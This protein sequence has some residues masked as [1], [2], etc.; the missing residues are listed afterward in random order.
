MTTA[1]MRFGMM[2]WVLPDWMPDILR[3]LVR[4][5]AITPDC[6]EMLSARC[7]RRSRF[8]LQLGNCRER[9]SL[10]N[11]GQCFE[12]GQPTRFGLAAATNGVTGSVP[13][14]LRHRRDGRS[15]TPPGRRVTTRIESHETVPYAI[16]RV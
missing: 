2:R 6:W 16:T 14:Q 1:K 15:P 3:R 7:V 11:C 5:A 10:G 9:G 13:T 8:F 12:D 4:D